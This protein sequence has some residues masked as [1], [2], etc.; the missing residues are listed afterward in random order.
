MRMMKRFL[1]LGLVFFLASSWGE[2]PK[3]QADKQCFTEEGLK[4]WP[5]DEREFI[6]GDVRGIILDKDNLERQA[7]FKKWVPKLINADC[8]VLWGS[9]LHHTINTNNRILFEYLLNETKASINQCDW[10]K[11]T[12]L[13]RALGENRHNLVRRLREKGAKEDSCVW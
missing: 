13:R 6:K 5:K 3:A 4:K 9:L 11:K 2:L 7:K 12:P 10:N 1:V 8:Y